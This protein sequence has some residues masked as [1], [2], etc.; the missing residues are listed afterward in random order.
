MALSLNEKFLNKFVS[1]EDIEGISEEIYNAQT[2]LT[3]KSL[4]YP[5]R[6]TDWTKRG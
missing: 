5:Q 3:E 4:S 6:I 2:T 1:E